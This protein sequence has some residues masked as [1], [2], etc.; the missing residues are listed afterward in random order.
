MD[1]Y[2]AG[3]EVSSHLSLLQE[4]GVTKVAV[5]AHNLGRNVKDAALLSWAS[6]QRL[7]ACEWI[8]Y[9]DS[10][11]TPVSIVTQVL[12]GAEVQPEAVTGPIEWYDTTWLK[13]SDLLFMPTWEATDPAQLREYVED[14]DGVMLP[15][16]VVDN[17]VSVRA[18]KAALPRM[19]QLGALTGRSRGLDRFDILVS[20]AWWA[21]QKHGET[22]VWTGDRLI[23]LNNED[24]GLKRE[25]Y[26]DAI[27]ALG[28]DV[29]A[30]IR[31]D[32]YEPMKLAVK[33]WLA[34]EQHIAAGA[35]VV[36]PAAPLVT[37]GAQAASPVV[38]PITPGV[39][40]P[41][42]PT[43]HHMLPVMGSRKTTQTV[44]G[45]DGKEVEVESSVLSVI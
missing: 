4:C 29:D 21:V 26:A 12:S 31:D 3:A 18:A 44:T 17:P 25:R 6:R 8:L 39:A 14:F 10:A 20:S 30:I 28:C 13:D 42:P 9:A 11:H 41:T 43:R 40:R 36:V 34:L 19:G 23:R 32:P 24:K 7:G 37:S 2:F 38:V 15:D 35:A 45:A 27:A 16:S 5:S 22:Q 1:L 33:S